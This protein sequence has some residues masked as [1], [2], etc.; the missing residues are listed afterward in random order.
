MYVLLCLIF[1][2]VLYLV[3][4]FAKFA[5]GKFETVRFK[6]AESHRSQLEP[7]LP[8]PISVNY[9]FTRRCNYE[10]GFCFHTAKTSYMLS[11]HDAKNGLRMLRDA[12]KSSSIVCCQELN[13]NSRQ[14]KKLDCVTFFL[15]VKLVSPF[16]AKKLFNR[17]LFSESCGQI[18]SSHFTST[19]S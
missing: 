1:A 18:E 12:G 14:N 5:R 7:C 6:C 10:C 11:L 9:H 3:I 2:T 17:T 15:F 16:M 4:Y 8:K 13:F 19:N